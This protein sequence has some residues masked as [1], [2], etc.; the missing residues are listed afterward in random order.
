MR[1]GGGEEQKKKQVLLTQHNEGDE[2]EIFINWN[3]LAK[4]II[5]LIFC[6]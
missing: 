2:N 3:I 5:K 1:K 4:W 6:N